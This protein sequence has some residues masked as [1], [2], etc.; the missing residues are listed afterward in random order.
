MND[1]TVE[2][3]ERYRRMLM[4]R[5]GAERVEMAFQMFDT[6][7]MLARAAFGDPEGIDRS[8]EMKERLF[9]RTYGREFDTQTRQRIVARL[10][11]LE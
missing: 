2:V 3:R 10:R 8:G 9:L 1:T 7:R 6:A 5:S 4:S 11:A